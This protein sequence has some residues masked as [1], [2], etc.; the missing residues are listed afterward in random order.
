MT[1][2]DAVNAVI[3]L[4]VFA[5]T[6]WAATSM[7]TG[8]PG[9]GYEPP[10]TASGAPDLQGTWT[11][12]TITSLERP[13]QINKLVLY[14]W[15]AEL[16][17]TQ[18]GKFFADNDP[19]DP[20]AGAPPAGEDVG[21]YNTFWMDPGTRLV[22]VNGQI[23][24]SIVVDPASGK[25]PYRA[26]YRRKL[27]NAIGSVFTDFDGPEQRPLGE[28][29]IVG[30][31]ST[32]GPPM[33]PV[34]YNNHYRF[35]QTPSHV[36]ILV[37]MNHDVR[38]VRLNGEHRSAHIKPWLGDSVGHWDGDTL[39]VETANFHPGQS[40]RAAIRHQLYMSEN[41]IVTERFT[42]V[43]DDQLHYEFTVEDPEVYTQTW[44]GETTLRGAAG[45]IYEYACHEGNY[46]LPGILAGA[47]ADEQTAA[48]AAGGD[49]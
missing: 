18:F 36:M 23:R 40:F 16:W 48:G 27:N 32:G 49:Q 41:T 6:I 5:V 24:S 9:A 43:A 15:E 20:D 47:R 26:E 7:A 14:E 19:S 13:D 35:V 10:R 22:R 17:E 4:L 25:V 39:V 29:C 30:F 28:R 42:R 1:G 45:R 34:L 31:G 33:L 12:A 11:N 46:S 38:I 8:Q 2:R 21:G 37:E 44:R 3:M